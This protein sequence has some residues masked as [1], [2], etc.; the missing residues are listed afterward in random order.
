MTLSYLED[1]TGRPA[2]MAPNGMV[3][4]PHALASQAG[5]AIL[6]AGGSAIDAAIA[7]QAVLCV[8]YPHMTG[9][10]GDG[11]WLTYDARNESV[12][13]LNAAGNAG[14]SANIEQ[15]RAAGHAEIPLRGPMPATLTVPGA[16]AGWCAAHARH[17]KLPLDA[18][19]NTAIRLAADGFPVSAR[20]SHWI[21]K[22]LPSG[23]MNDAA[24]AIFAP[25]GKVPEAG[26][27][28]V[29][30]DLAATLGS[31]AK[32]GHRGFYEGDVARKMAEYAERSGGFFTQVDFANQQAEWGV[33]LASTYRDVT[34]FETP[35]PTQGFTVLSMLNM[36]E[37]WD[38]GGWA[39]N[40]PDHVHHLVQAK[41]LAYHDRDQLLADPTRSHV[42]VE[43]LLSK[44]YAATQRARV[45]QHTALPWDA[46]ASGG[47]LR[48][49]T[50]FV[51][52]VDKDG[53]AA[54]SI[55]SLYG[56][57]GSG[58]VVPGTG[59][60]LQN[61][62]AYFSLDPDHPNRLEPGKQPA[63]TLIA[64]LAFRDDRLWQVLGC[65]GADGQPQI[66]L[67]TYCGL[68]DFGL[69]IQQAVEAP[70]WL[71]GRF[72]LGEPRDLLNIE[73]RFSENTMRELE[74]R[75]HKLNR[76]Q[77]WNELAGH[78]HGITI[79]PTSAMRIGGADP[80]SDGAA[81]GY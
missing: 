81:V 55:Q 4:S 8:V 24:E 65:M 5:T 48:G 68:I 6:G 64:S 9:I 16:V 38:V 29:N 28:L 22:V 74:A 72:A 54:S 15:F 35:P 75:G 49:D 20:L 7:T 18:V 53:N 67:Q 78:C 69:D 33:P 25:G 39:H 77:R 62:S 57:F 70:R 12:D 34:V 73:G 13:Y 79:S 37:G 56:I 43:H 66:H 2:T 59:V 41:Q 36:A 3:V 45:S 27:A 1:G 23:A 19:L 51:G 31:I 50:V 40:G 21:A 60:V 47:T 61:R 14:A 10:G 52:V 42:P 58:C 80:R 44:V 30:P 63:H 71:S 17:G 46:I 26:S 11:F 76:W 32:G